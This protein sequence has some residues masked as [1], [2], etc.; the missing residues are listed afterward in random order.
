[1]AYQS[2]APEIKKSIFGANL[3]KRRKNQDGTDS[4]LVHIFVEDDEAWYGPKLSFDI[5]WIDELIDV[6]N[7]VK[8]RL[9]PKYRK[10]LRKV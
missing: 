4:P 9:P 3:V 2:E 1:M 6:L 7:E 8:R 5:H 10:Y